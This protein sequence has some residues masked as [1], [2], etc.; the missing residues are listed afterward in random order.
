MERQLNYIIHLMDK[1]LI[2][3]E[4]WGEL[5]NTLHI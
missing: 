4:S 3:S 5:E 1:F 2:F